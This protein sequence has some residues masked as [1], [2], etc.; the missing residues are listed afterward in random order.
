VLR[1]LAE[2][3]TTFVV[4]Y[5]YFYSIAGKTALGLNGAGSGPGSGVVQVFHKDVEKVSETWCVAGWG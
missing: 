1:A 4:L 3:L 2:Q 5:L